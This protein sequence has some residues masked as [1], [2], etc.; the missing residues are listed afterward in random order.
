M[1]TQ[2]QELLRKRKGSSTFTEV[3]DILYR[4]SFT[5][6]RK[7]DFNNKEIYKNIFQK[8]KWAGVFQFTEGGAQAFCKRAKPTSLIDIAAITSIFRPGPLS[9]KVDKEYVKA[10]ENPRRY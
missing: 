4:Q 1:K 8:G 3:K 6:R 10:K 7:L 5:S 2:S 9:A